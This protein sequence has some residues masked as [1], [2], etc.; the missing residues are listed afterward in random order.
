MFF[1]FELYALDC[2]TIVF[3]KILKKNHYL[4]AAHKDFG[5]FY[6]SSYVAAPDGTRTPVRTL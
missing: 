2:L 5:H 1:I 6:G 3:V 4:F